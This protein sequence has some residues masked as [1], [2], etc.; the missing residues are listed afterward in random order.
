MPRFA[1]LG[2]F[3]L[4]GTPI[5][6][7]QPHKLLLQ[8]AD[9]Y[10]KPTQGVTFTIQG[11]S[12]KSRPTDDSG[13]TEIVL[14][15]VIKAG[16]SVVIVVVAPNYVV[17]D[18][19]NQRSVV[20]PPYESR[21]YVQVRLMKPGDKVQIGQFLIQELTN[22]NVQNM[23]KSVVPGAATRTRE[24]NI[25][26]FI[27]E[28]GITRQSFDAAMGM[29]KSKDPYDLGTLALFQCR[30]V[31]AVDHF[32]TA[33]KEAQSDP[34]T[35][36]EKLARIMSALGQAQFLTADYGKAVVVYR[37]AAKLV[38]DD[39]ALLN[40]FAMALARATDL[41]GA[42][43]LFRR[44]LELREQEVRKD[45]HD[46]NSG[47]LAVALTN[48]GYILQEQHKCALAEPLLVRA[49]GIWNKVLPDRDL[50]LAAANDNVAKAKYCVGDYK[51]AGEH[52]EQQVAVC[53][54]VMGAAHPSCTDRLYDA[55]ANLYR[56]RMF[57]MAESAFRRA[58]ANWDKNLLN[59]ANVILTLRYLGWIRSEAR[60]YQ[61]AEEFLSRAIQE[62]RALAGTEGSRSA[63]ASLIFDLSEVYREKG[64]D[65]NQEAWTR[66]LLTIRKSEPRSPNR[67]WNIAIILR[68]L[69]VLLYNRQDFNAA[70]ASAKEVIE[71][72]RNAGRLND[73]MIAEMRSV[74]DKVNSADRAKQ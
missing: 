27:R 5:A 28:H 43:E 48:L 68:N 13:K 11:E 4:L 32:S 57:P 63:E 69:T 19:F 47:E 14:G 49:L 34:A 2:A 41:S 8:A 62:Q 39:P 56:A 38:P 20:V 51:G 30:Y 50:T 60:D 10:G 66:Q 61:A 72:G 74:I 59:R 18:L 65:R 44:T 26:A 7:G 33:L 31:E 71:Y 67:D 12:G 6:Y 45:G 22:S 53:E 9:V 35:K 58:L 3:A 15:S 70:Q 55:A 1:L 17:F 54:R 36:P 21:T 42:E 40:N 37:Q 29:L 25:D 23:P 73:P 52:W 46:P 24:Q 16:S 64:D